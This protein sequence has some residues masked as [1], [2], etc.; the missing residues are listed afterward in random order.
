MTLKRV[1]GISFWLTSIAALFA[2]CNGEEFDSAEIAEEEST[3]EVAD[4]LQMNC[5]VGANCGLTW[6]K[7]YHTNEKGQ[8]AVSC[9]DSTVTPSES[10]NPYTGDTDCKLSRPILCIRKDGSASNGFV[11]SFYN[12]WAA[13]NLGITHPIAGTSL[14][15]LAAANG[16]CVSEFGPGWQMAEHHDGGGGWGFT[17]YGNLNTKYMS[18]SPTHTLAD[19]F[20]V[21]VNDQPQ[22]NC[23]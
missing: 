2:G 15:S 1:F 14:T 16:Y 5:P 13:G 12:G 22:G 6:V 19:R 3:A 18:A 4:A 21:H 20:W 7:R 10:C 9:H 23:W 8:D 11:G 17:A